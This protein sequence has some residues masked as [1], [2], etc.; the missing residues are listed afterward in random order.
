VTGVQTC[1][2]PIYALLAQAN[3]YDAKR[4]GSLRLMKDGGIAK[5]DWDDGDLVNDQV[6]FLSML[7]VSRWLDAPGM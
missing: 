6:V 1:A 3:N 2:L 4:V 7:N 5:M